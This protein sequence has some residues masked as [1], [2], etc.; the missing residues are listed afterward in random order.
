[1]KRDPGKLAERWRSLVCPD[2]RGKVSAATDSNNGWIEGYLAV[3]G[4]L[5][6]RNEI[7]EPGMFA[8]SAAERIPAG[9]VP[10]MTRHFAYGGDVP[11]VVGLITQGKEDDY[12]LFIH[13]DFSKVARA[14]ETRQLINEGVAWGLSVGFELLRFEEVKEADGK[15]VLRLLEGRLSEGTI[16]V[17]PMNEKAVITAAKSNNPAEGLDVERLSLDQL[18]QARE[19]INDA[20]RDLQ[21]NTKDGTGF[22]LDAEAYRRH[23]Q[24]QRQAIALAQLGV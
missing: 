3:F 8:K 24:L 9:R 23:L 21:A 7:V 13:A 10:L 2:V 18:K 4:N 5:D 14:Q 16:T 11:D 17:R 19:R 12:G 20:L 1:M 6:E 22:T 15:T